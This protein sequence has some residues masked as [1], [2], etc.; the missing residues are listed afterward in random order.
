MST[1]FAASVTEWNN[2]YVLAGS[3]SATLIGLL[4]VSVSLHIDVLTEDAARSI[5]AGARRTFS[6]FIIIVVMALL[7]LVPEESPH[8]LGST[9][10]VLG[11]LDAFNNLR[12][13]VLARREAANWQALLG[14]TARSLVAV[15][16]PLF[17]SVGLILVALSLYQG[18]TDGLVWLVAIVAGI[19]TGAAGNAWDLMLS[20]AK[21]KRRRSERQAGDT[22]AL[23]H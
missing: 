8:G 9:L 15:I 22:G 2:F 17:S 21:A 4:F 18:K 6:R 14:D 10:L 7:F 1:P 13:I 20:L 19:L 5:L 12:L 11:A 23:D 3:A 16:V